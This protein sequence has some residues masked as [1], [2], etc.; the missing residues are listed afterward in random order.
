MSRLEQLEGEAWR[1]FVSAPIAV[2]VLSDST[3]PV[4]KTWSEEL[5]AFLEADRRWQGV[6]FGEIFLDDGADPEEEEDEE[7]GNP[8]ALARALSTVLS[9]I[10]GPQ[11][12]F[13]RAN[14]DWLAKVEDLPHN[15]LYVQGKRIK[16]WPGAG[17]DRLVTRL[18]GVESG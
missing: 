9:S 13:A 16:A 5:T 18:E 15:V 14:R 17:I 4:C 12:S 3:C 2:L 10:V 11:G 1:E 6:R 8:E 7:D